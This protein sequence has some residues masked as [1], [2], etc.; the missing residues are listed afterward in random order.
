M[1][2]RVETRVAVQCDR[3]CVMTA[4]R[5]V[6]IAAVVAG[7]ALVTAPMVLPAAGVTPPPMPAATPTGDWVPGWTPGADA[8]DGQTREPS[9]DRLPQT[10][11]GP[12]ALAV[13]AAAGLLAGGGWLVVRG[14]RR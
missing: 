4:R 13:L 5:A 11:T 6:S 12:E 10:G 8:P 3:G 1:S 7:V 2:R 14:W 9:G